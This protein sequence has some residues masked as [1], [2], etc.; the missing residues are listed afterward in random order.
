M[1]V[2]IKNTPRHNGDSDSRMR[3]IQQYVTQA[4][5]VNPKR[6]MRSIERLCAREAG[7]LGKVMY[8]YKDPSV[9]GPT[10]RSLVASVGMG[11]NTVTAS[12][13]VTEPPAADKTNGVVLQ[14]E[15]DG[16][17]DWMEKQNLPKLQRQLVAGGYK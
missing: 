15:T 4:P 2:V 5:F 12:T 10:N 6:I 13:A 14:P 1:F 9:M 3:Q 17:R 7:S 16:F 11:R 8:R